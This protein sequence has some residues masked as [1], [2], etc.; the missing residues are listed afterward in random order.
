MIMLVASFAFAPNVV[1]QMIQI[2]TPSNGTVSKLHSQVVTA[3]GWEG[4]DAQLWM[5]GTLAQSG[6]IRQDGI[7]DFMNVN[8]PSG[9][10][11]FE[12]RLVN[13]DGSIVENDSV[14]IHILGAPAFVKIALSEDHLRANGAS[15]LIGKVE[16]LDEWGYAIQEDY[17]VTINVDAGKLLTHDIDPQKPGTQIQL[18]RGYA[19]F[20]YQAPATQGTTTITAE[21]E[22]AKSTASVKID[23]PLEPLTVVGLVNGSASAMKA[24][25]DL[26]R[27]ADPSSF[28]DGLTTDGRIAASARGT[29]DGDYFLTASYDSDRKNRDKLFRDLDPDYLYSIYGD[30]SMLSYDAQTQSPL[31]V[32]IEKNQSY[33]LVGD[34]NTDLS[35]QEFTRYN[36]SLSGVKT[37]IKVGG[38]D[39]KA[40]GSLTD[41]KVIHNE[42][43][44]EGLSGYYNLG[45]P[46]YRAGLE[47]QIR[48]ETRD[49]YHPE[50]LINGADQSRSRDYVIDYDQGT[51]FFTQPVPSVDQFGNPVWITVTFEAIT[52]KASTYVAGTNV[53]HSFSENLTV[54]LSGITEEQS[55]KNY[56]L[57]GA[58]TKYQLGG[59]FSISG[60]IAHSANYMLV[61]NEQSSG[62]AYKMEVTG[63]PLTNLS[64]RGYYRRMG[65]GFYNIRES[66]SQ[67]ERGSIRYGASGGYRIRQ[68]HETFCGIL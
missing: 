64:L 56:Y 10:V 39:V 5:N 67:I 2:L 37:D 42:I 32:K 40:F 60:E 52:D 53:E 22:Q 47:K 16:V 1:A 57:F 58:N 3:K 31:F 33:L 28:P 48:I 23:V 50:I 41:H 38:W 59:K 30:N 12:A 49:R 13:P 20:E 61:N 36:R 46:R 26:T 62:T 65:D 14:K 44:G 66:G 29:I 54:G 18:V 8:V 6:K 34:F 51:V 17:N 68:D 24:S 9:D 63:S 7:I 45:G 35:L 21:V 19:E 25:G 15:T 27:V 55:P 43:R 4:F 11:K